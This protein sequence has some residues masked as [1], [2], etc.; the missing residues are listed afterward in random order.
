MAFVDE[1][2]RY[3]NRWVA[4]VYFG[5]ERQSVVGSGESIREARAE[6]ESKGFTDFSFLRVPPSDKLFVPIGAKTSAI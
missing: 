5:T 3:V 1:L 4:I 6:A 2:D